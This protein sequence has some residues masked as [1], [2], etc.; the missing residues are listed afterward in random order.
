LVI[1]CWDTSSLMIKHESKPVA[2]Q[3]TDAWANAYCTF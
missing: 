2:M 1:G 3:A